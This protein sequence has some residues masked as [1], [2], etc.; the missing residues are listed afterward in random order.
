MCI[1]CGLNRLHQLE[2]VLFDADV[3]A[4]HAKINSEKQRMP[5]WIRKKVSS[6]PPKLS[7]RLLQ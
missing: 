4:F 2:G 5:M 3:T 1:L 7:V 6:F